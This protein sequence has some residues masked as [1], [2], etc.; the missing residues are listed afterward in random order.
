MYNTL[1]LTKASHVWLVLGL[2]NV[3]CIPSRITL[4]YTRRQHLICW[5]LFRVL[6]LWINLKPFCIRVWPPRV[7][8]DNE[9]NRVSLCH[10]SCVKAQVS[11]VFRRHLVYTHIYHGRRCGQFHWGTFKEDLHCWGGIDATSYG[12]TVIDGW[13][14]VWESH[15]CKLVLI[16]LF[17][18]EDIYHS[19]WGGI[20]MSLAE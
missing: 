8:I 19:L 14:L 7:R 3:L 12:T 2:L 11:N 13:I 20:C 9:I 18:M 4:L 15:G 17:W 6:F 10:L 16:Q 5:T 1:S